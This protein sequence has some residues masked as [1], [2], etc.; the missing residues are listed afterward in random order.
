MGVSSGVSW[1]FD[2]EPEG[3]IVE[4][5]V[6]PEPAF[7]RFCEELLEKFRHDER[8]AMINGSNFVSGH[9]AA[10]ES[11]F[12]S[13]YPYI[14]GWASWRRSWQA[15]DVGMKAWPAWRDSG[16][17][18]SLSNGKPLVE[19]YWRKILEATYAGKIDT[20]DYQWFFAVWRQS[21]LAVVPSRN[22]ITNLGYGTDA[23]H[24]VGEVPSFVLSSPAE[25]LS[26]PLIHPTT[27]AAAVRAD[28]LMETN[29]FGIT[30]M[31]EIKHVTRSQP[32][33][34]RLASL[35]KS[36]ARRT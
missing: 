28:R 15:Y 11:Y 27:V 34:G 6:L 5:D 3:I 1:F 19:R 14:W 31:N 29:V 18:K 4:D 10:K 35:M 17:L 30:R 23:T 24:T 7:F 12:Y 33:Y 13:R 36:F 16:G 32:I 22:Q 2:Q 9:F 20:W 8:I 21:K 26:F 25:Q